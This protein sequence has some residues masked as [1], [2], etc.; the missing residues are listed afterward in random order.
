[1]KKKSEEIF[2]DWLRKNCKK[3]QVVRVWESENIFVV[4]NRPIP[5]K[6]IKGFLSTTD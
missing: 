6:E 3:G 4:S 5:A 2:H 1:M